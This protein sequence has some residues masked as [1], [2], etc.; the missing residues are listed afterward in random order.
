MIFAALYLAVCRKHELSRTRMTVA[1]S[2]GLLLAGAATFALKQ[3]MPALP[4]L[5]VTVLV[6][7]PRARRVP[8]QDWFATGLAAALLV[9]SAVR[10]AR[11]G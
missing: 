11:Q 4:F 1:I 2:I 5:G 8:R 3:P 10:V 7:E 9:A 6:F